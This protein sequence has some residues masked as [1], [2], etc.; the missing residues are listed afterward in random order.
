MKYADLSKIFEVL[1]TIASIPWQINRKI[2][3][4]VEQVWEEGGGVAYIPK[5]HYDF[6]DFVYEYQIKECYSTIE[7]MKMQKKL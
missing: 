6:S 5:R 3:N 2:L 4:V 7:K 1:D